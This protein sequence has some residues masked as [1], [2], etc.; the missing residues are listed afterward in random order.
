LS[1]TYI[2]TDL[3]P[4]NILIQ[5]GESI[6]G[7]SAAWVLPASATTAPAN[8]ATPVE[9]AYFNGLMNPANILV[10]RASVAGDFSPYTLR[11]VNDNSAASLD[12]FEVTEALAGFDPQLAEG[13]R[14]ALPPTPT[15]AIVTR[16]A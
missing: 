10:V 2:P 15:S 7:I 16:C 6:T 9:L 1:Q 8:T 12:I 11:L 3:T 14:R 4:A 5:G 13:T